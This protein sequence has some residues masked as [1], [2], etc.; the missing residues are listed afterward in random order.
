MLCNHGWE[1]QQTQ[2]P[3]GSGPKGSVK[4]CNTKRFLLQNKKQNSKLDNSLNYN[5]I[6]GFEVSFP[7]LE[8]R[9]NLS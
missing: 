2:R 8:N 6:D 7:F 5:F 9:Y 4:K 3:K 1:K